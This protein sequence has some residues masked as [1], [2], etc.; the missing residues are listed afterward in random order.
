MRRLHRY[1]RTG[2]SELVR[3]HRTIRSGAT[4]PVLSH[5]RKCT[6]AVAP[7]HLLVPVC[8]GTVAPVLLYESRYG[9]PTYASDR[10]PVSRPPPKA[11]SHSGNRILSPSR[12][13]TSVPV[14]LHSYHRSRMGEHRRRTAR[15]KQRRPPNSKGGARTLIS[16]GADGTVAERGAGQMA[17]EQRHVNTMASPANTTI[18]DR[19]R[20]RCAQGEATRCTNTRTGPLA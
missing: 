7:V 17:N 1:N 16:K 12:S 6:G 14:R 20:M 9:A 5:R 13:S 4:V 18:T 15:W 10:C 8:T 19:I 3:S 11:K 2:A